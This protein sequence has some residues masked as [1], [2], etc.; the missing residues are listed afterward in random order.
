MSCDNFCDECCE[1]LLGNMMSDPTCRDSSLVTTA[2]VIG[3]L[4][5]VGAV[6]AGFAA[7]YNAFLRPVLLGHLI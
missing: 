7:Y 1:T 4:T 2:G 6:L 3:I 5:F